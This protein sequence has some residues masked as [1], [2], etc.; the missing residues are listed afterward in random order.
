MNISA[1]TLTFRRR[2]RESQMKSAMERVTRLF[3]AHAIAMANRRQ[4]DMQETE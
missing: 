3:G 2:G 4:W 1:A